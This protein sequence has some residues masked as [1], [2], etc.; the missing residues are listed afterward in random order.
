MRRISL[1]AVAVSACLVGCQPPAEEVVPKAKPKASTSATTDDTAKKEEPKKESDDKKAEAPA[2]EATPPAAAPTTPGAETPAP[3][4]APTTPPADTPAPAPTTPPA[5]G[6]APATPPT[7]PGAS[8]ES[9]AAVRFV[10][11]KKLQVPGMSCPYGCYP[12]VEKTLASLPGVKGVQLAK[13]PEGT[14]EGDLT[15]KVVELKLGEGFDLQAALAA[16]KKVNFEATEI[17]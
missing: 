7:N 8:L 14:A 1:L 13:Q 2:A 9:G 12:T 5:E 4:P 17:N 11:D 6:A 16:L 3:A 10:A 15:L